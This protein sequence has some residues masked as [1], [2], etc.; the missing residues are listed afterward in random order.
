MAYAGKDALG[1]ILILGFDI[2]EVRCTLKLG[3]P[4]DV[5]R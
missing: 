2:P 1:L 5:Q 4:L 3:R